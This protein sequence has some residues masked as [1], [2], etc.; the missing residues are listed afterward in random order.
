MKL[1]SVGAAGHE[2]AGVLLP[3]GVLRVGVEVR[4][5]GGP[6]GVWATQV[7]RITS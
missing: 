3:G 5:E 2:E 6:A 4:V 1:V 7:R